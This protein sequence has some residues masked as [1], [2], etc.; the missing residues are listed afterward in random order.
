MKY[1]GVFYALFAIIVAFALAVVWR[2]ACSNIQEVPR[3]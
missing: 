2:A 1:N 3:V